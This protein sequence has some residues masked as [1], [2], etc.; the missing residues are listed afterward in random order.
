MALNKNKF[1]ELVRS[2]RKQRGWTQEELAERWGYTRAYI[3][4]IE[5]G[6]KRLDSIVQVL[7]LADILDIP[8]E[9]L[10]AI[11]RGIPERKIK[12]VSSKQADSA[13]LQML[14]APGRDMARLSYLAWVA[15]QQPA[16]EENLHDLVSTLELALVSYHG[17]FSKPAQQ[18]LSYAHQMQGRIAYDR[19]DFASA[20]GHFSEMIDLGRE[21]NDPDIITVGMVRQGSILRKRGRIE[22]A[23][24]CFE[25]AKPYAEVA[26]MNVQGQRHLHT[27]TAYADLGDEQ[28]F[29]RSINPALDIASSMKPTISSLANEFSLDEVLCSQSTGFSELWKPEKALEIYKET[30][31][32]RSFRPL[33]E[34]GR[35]IIEKGQ[36]HLYVGDLDQGIDMSLKGLALASEY[37]SKRHVGWVEKTYNRLRVLPI[38]KDKRLNTLHD[39]LVDAQRQQEKW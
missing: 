25:A 32:L 3:S 1:G 5:A 26:S 21:L 27:A 24:R 36:A 10:E 34:Q 7:R 31:Q 2:Y 19:L 23:L 12:V 39:A 20:S 29:I 9:K 4:Q 15:D 33:R 37:H 16:I 8:S 13:I 38:G 28:G 6:K 17:E 22:S 11:G 35:Y 30:D 18:L 14:L